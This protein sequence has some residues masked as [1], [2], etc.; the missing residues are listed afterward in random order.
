[1]PLLS[2]IFRS[3]TDEPQE[4]GPNRTGL[5]VFTKCYRRPSVRIRPVAPLS[6][7]STQEKDR[8]G[9]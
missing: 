6:A 4:Q 2:D 7:S 8:H 5:A 1:M 9:N 3:V